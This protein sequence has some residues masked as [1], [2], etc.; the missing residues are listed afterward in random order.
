MALPEPEPEAPASSGEVKASSTKAVVAAVCAAPGAA[1]RTSRGVS[2]A[3]RASIASTGTGSFQAFLRVMRFLP[4]ARAP[5]SVLTGAKGREEGV[6]PPC[7]H[8][9]GGG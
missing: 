3:A 7:F 4:G 8:K 1:S 2:S 9:G 6:S 5:D